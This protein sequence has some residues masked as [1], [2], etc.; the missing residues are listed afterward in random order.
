[1]T[2]P[3]PTAASSDH[4]G[5][6]FPGMRNDIEAACPC[7]KAACGLVIQDEVTEACGQHHWSAAK[8]MRQSHPAAECPVSPAGQAPTTDQAENAA[9]WGEL[10]RRDA[11]TDQA[12]A[13][14]EPATDQ[15]A[16]RVVAY[17]SPGTRTLYCVICAR[18]EEGWTPLT[19]DKVR[20]GAVCDFCGGRVLAVASRMLG[21]V[22]ASYVDA[23]DQTALRDRIAAAI[24]ERQNPGRRWADCEYRWQ[25]DAEADADAV[26]SVLPASVDRASVLA[27]VEC[28]VRTE[29]S[30]C[31]YPLDA[32]C[33]YCNG[34]TTVLEKVRRLAAPSAVVV[35]RATDET[36]GE[37]EPCT[38]GGTFPLNHLHAD[39]HQ[40]AVGAQQPKE[41]RP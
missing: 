21:S 35:R 17:R 26:L 24:W 16:P 20:E 36:P 15:T 40:P 7:P 34:V 18:Q 39:T 2:Q 5:R 32:G 4:I 10:H 6:S 37:A 30:N 9:L 11:E 14:A 25:A 12:H 41:T 23:T 31:G 33:D 8:T 28:V 29:I 27:E 1:M 22:V 38:C 3:D 19:A 13:D